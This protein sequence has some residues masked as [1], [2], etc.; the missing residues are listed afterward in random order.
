M[1]VVDL[2][3]GTPCPFMPNG[4]ENSQP[5]VAVYHLELVSFPRMRAN[6]QRFVPARGFNVSSELLE[7]LRGHLVAAFRMGFQLAHRDFLNHD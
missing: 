1:I 4:F 6:D 5:V 7:R 3:D 2:P